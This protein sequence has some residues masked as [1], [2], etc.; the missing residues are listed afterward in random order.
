MSSSCSSSVKCLAELGKADLNSL[1]VL[2]PFLRLDT[3]D[4]I[5]EFIKAIVSRN[6]ISKVIAFILLVFL[7]KYSST[8]IFFEKL[9]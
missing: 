3:K 9:M 5:D 6:R 7:Q 1:G 8:L 4:S 2:Q